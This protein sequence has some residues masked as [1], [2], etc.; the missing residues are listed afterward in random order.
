MMWMT[1]TGQWCKTVG[2]LTSKFKKLQGVVGTMTTEEHT[3][4]S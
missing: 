3:W 1:E 4:L 2:N